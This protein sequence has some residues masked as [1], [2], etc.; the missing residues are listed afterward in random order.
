MAIRKI[1][2]MH[3][4]YGICEGHA[5]GEC[6][7]LVDEEHHGKTTCKCKV[8]GLTSSAASDWARR[9]L[10]CG[11]FNKSYKG[12]PNIEQATPTRTKQEEDKP[13]EL[14]GQM[15]LEV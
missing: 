13:Y 8:Y 5:C 1:E 15:K 9:Y 2:K 4:I 7:N 14:E 11:M 10:A 6:S 12:R 3:R